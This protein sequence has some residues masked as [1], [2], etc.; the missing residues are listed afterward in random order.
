MPVWLKKILPVTFLLFSLCPLAALELSRTLREADRLY[1]SG[2]YQQAITLAQKAVKIDSSNL[3]ANLIMGMSYF[4]GK[5]YVKARACFRKA[6][7]INAK[8]PIV[9]RYI[10]VIQEIEHRYGPFSQS[11][12]AQK[13]SS[14]PVTRNNAFK[15]AWF[16]HSFPSESAPREDYFDPAKNLPAPVALEVEA[17]IERILIKNTV[18]NMAQ[19][20]LK[21]QKYLKSYLFYSQLNSSEPANREYILGKAKSAYEL[22]RYN[23]VIKILGPIILASGK[24][25]KNKELYQQ[26]KVLLKEARARLYALD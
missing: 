25:F 16:G 22:K 26:A 2:N 1:Q 10:R 15:K 20:A 19:K 4:N 17:P 5:N 9:R 24:N 8:H 18:A 21:E 11:I 13:E 7:Q 3:Q 6:A 23:E 12:I 14:D